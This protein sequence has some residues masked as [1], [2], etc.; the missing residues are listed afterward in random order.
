[1]SKKKAVQNKWMRDLIP[2]HFTDLDY[3]FEETLFEGLIFF[4]EQ[5]GGKES[6]ELNSQPWEDNGFFHWSPERKECYD[7]MKAAY[8]WGKTRH[9]SEPE[10]P[11]LG[12]DWKT[13]FRTEAYGD[14]VKIAN[15]K[16]VKWEEEKDTHVTNILKYR[17]YL[18][19]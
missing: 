1:M 9:E 11:S 5:D 14:A 17:K 12:D 16:L 15:E 10:Y 3:L 7:L 8:E 19:T 13:T 6:L 4:W 2:D 18:W